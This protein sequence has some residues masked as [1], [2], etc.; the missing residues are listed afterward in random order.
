MIAGDATFVGKR[1]LVTGATG[2]VGRALVSRIESLRASVTR[3]STHPS[4][5]D[6]GWDPQRGLLQAP[7]RLEAH[8]AAIHLAGE[9][10][11]GRWT[12][13]KKRKIRD[14][15]VEGTRLLAEG[16][17]ACARKPDVLVCASA[18]GFYGAQREEPVNEEAPSGRGFLAEVCR[19]W[20]AA[21][22]PA[23]KAGIR[24]VHLRFGIILSPDGGA[25]A[26]MLRPF[27]LGLG[28]PVGGGSQWVSWISLNDA[29][30]AILH[31][32]ACKGVSGPVNAVAPHLVTNAELA[33]TLGHVLGRPAV[34]P[35]PAAA[36]RLLM[37]SEAAEET[38]LS[39][40]Q[41]RPQKLVE[42]G[43]RFEDAALEPALRRLLGEVG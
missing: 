41:A 25:L 33:R 34:V 37:G 30:Q 6:I 20:E 18:I 8:N 28:G 3:V 7:E 17:A 19:E 31:A 2:F 4:A 21:A 39:S 13:E 9:T 1:F 5:G 26:Q 32:V 29:V 38:V 10:V 15:R 24:V 27:R 12:S 14:S 23:R 16:L 43:F 35:V 22:E 42:T 40:V 36:L 11:L